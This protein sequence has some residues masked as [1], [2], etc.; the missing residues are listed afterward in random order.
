VSGSR[1]GS[2]RVALRRKPLDP[3]LSHLDGAATETDEHGAQACAAAAEL[4]VLHGDVDAGH[5]TLQA[6][7]PKV[8][9]Q[10]PSPTSSPRV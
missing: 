4:V 5:A 7:W 10:Q 3:H 1:P 2:T 9:N 8:L 6:A